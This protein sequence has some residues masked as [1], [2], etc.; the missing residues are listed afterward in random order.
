MAASDAGA[1]E[2]P[3]IK[4]SRKKRAAKPA[5]GGEAK[6]A[7]Q[8]ARERT[9]ATAGAGDRRVAGQ[10]EDDQEVPGRRLHGEGLGRPRQGSAQVEDGRGCRAR[11]RAR[12]RDHPR[13]GKVL[14]EI[15]KAAKQV[16]TVYL[17]PDPDREGEAIAWH[18][19]E[20]IGA[21]AKPNIKR[22]LFNEI[23]KR[24]ITEAHQ[25]PAASS[26]P[27]KF[28]SQ[29][30]RRILDRLVGYQ[31]SPISV[32]EGAAR[33]VGGPGAVGGGA[34]RGRARA[35]DQGLH[36]RR[37]LDHRGATSTAANPP[38]FRAR[39]QA[40][41]AEAELKNRGPG[42]QARR[43]DIASGDVRS[44]ERRT[45]G[46]QARPARRLSSPRSCSRRPRAS[47]ASRAKRTMAMAQRLYEGLE[48]GEEGRVGL[49]TYMRT[50]STRLSADAVARSA[51]L[52]RRAYGAEP[53]GRAQHLQLQEGRAGRARGHPPDLDEVRSG[54][55][56]AC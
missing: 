27:S 22:M 23:T 41:R 8:P 38:P 21:A 7:K 30:A 28:D 6:L 14:T 12:L 15:K 45:Q 18:I 29:Q 56:R 34:H 47:C 49:I 9:R 11:L 53:A 51:R 50:D 13:Q 44:S 31:I 33:P 39:G 5:A 10:G 24:A 2:A 36:A 32:E 52:H 3:A 42:Q 1:P 26:T 19:A 17:A 48:L 55:V 46:A 4:K 16:E 20:E 35:R 25:A 40:R 37:V 54:T 43:R